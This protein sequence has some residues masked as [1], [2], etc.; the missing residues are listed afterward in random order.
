M[1]YNDFDGTANS[2]SRHLV[3]KISSDSLVDGKVR[4]SNWRCRTL[5]LSFCT[6]RTYKGPTVVIRSVV[7]YSTARESASPSIAICTVPQPLVPLVSLWPSST[8]H[9]SKIRRVAAEIRGTRWKRA[10]GKGRRGNAAR[11]GAALS[12]KYLRIIPL[13]G[14]RHEN[15]RRT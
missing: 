1:S 2:V 4:A 3:T 9:P 7:A 5:I 6:T 14:K 10:R 11:Y 13:A 15:F 12:A 8:D